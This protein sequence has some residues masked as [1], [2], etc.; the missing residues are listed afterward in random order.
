M[1]DG[2][3]PGVVIGCKVINFICPKLGAVETLI[4]VCHVP[5]NSR[6]WNS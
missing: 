6:M 1:V 3:K 2:E 5:Q 4:H